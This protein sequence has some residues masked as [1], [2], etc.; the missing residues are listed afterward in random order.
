ML[1]FPWFCIWCIVAIHIRSVFGMEYV[2]CIWYGDACYAVE[3]CSSYSVFDA[4]Y[5]C[6]VVGMDH[7]VNCVFVKKCLQ[8]V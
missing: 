2:V 7:G 3:I 1:F 8:L 4:T 5:N 6:S